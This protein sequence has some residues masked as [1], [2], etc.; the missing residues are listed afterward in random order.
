MAMTATSFPSMTDPIHILGPEQSC[1]DATL[2]DG[3][4][5][6][7]PGARSYC[8]FRA[9]RDTK[10]DTLG[11]TYHHHVDMAA[12]KGKLYVGWNTC[13]KDEDLWPSRELLSVSEDG[14][15]WSDPI[16]MFPQGVSTPLRMYFYLAPNGRMLIIAG[17]RPDEGE[18]IE[19][20]KRGLVVREL[21]ADHT[22]G[23]VYTLQPLGDDARGA[24]FHTSSDTGFVQ[25]CNSL[26]AD[27]VYLEQ[28][29]RGRL[30]LGDR[31]MKWHDAQHW[32]GGVL[33]GTKEGEENVKWTFGKALTFFRRPD[34]AIVGICKMGWTV[35]SSDEGNSWSPPVVPKSLVT[36][37]AKVFAQNHRDGSISL[38]YNPST[39][40]RFPLAIVRST[41]GVNF[42]G[43]RL[44][45]GELPRQRYEG[46]FRSIGPQYVRGLSQWSDDRSRDEPCTWLVYS[47]NKEDIWVSR[48]PLPIIPEP[49]DTSDN[50]IAYQPKWG[51]VELVEG[52]VVLLCRDPYDYASA[53]RVF[54]ATRTLSLDLSLTVSSLP[55]DRIEIDLHSTFGPARP[56]RIGI[57]P[58]GGIELNEQ[59]AGQL[60]IGQRSTLRL[61]VDLN[62]QR[63]LLSIGDNATVTQLPTIGLASDLSRLVVRTGA[64]RNIGG[65]KPVEPGTDVPATPIFVTLHA[66]RI[67]PSL[68][69]TNR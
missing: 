36:G 14:V 39:G 18:T 8:V 65:K 32:P 13:L 55:R 19:D 34:R 4:L 63:V 51:Q 24:M 49:T 23:D 62:A 48:M 46:R 22:F 33:P 67:D 12:W 38:A 54:N 52:S 7:L 69:S 37:K 60:A 28:Q 17:L 44:I 50:W 45:Q 53:T 43:M 3:G 29:D 56:V 30:L 68:H 64:F 26:L 9:S 61:E 57:T 41:D 35:V 5:P 15:N 40:Q 20:N 66:V 16:E 1:L 11:Y 31:P 58:G 59:S 10:P 2:A 42:D 27:R 6:P 21:R 25:A 47:M